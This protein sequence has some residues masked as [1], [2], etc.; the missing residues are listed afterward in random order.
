MQ[1]T[2]TGVLG[3]VLKT[4]AR[5][6]QW[7]DLVFSQFSSKT[8]AHKTYVTHV[9]C[10]DMK[11]YTGTSCKVCEN[12]YCLNVWTRTSRPTDLVGS[13]PGY[14]F[15]LHSSQYGPLDIFSHSTAANMAQWIFFTLLSS[16]R[17]AMDFLF[18]RT[19]QQPT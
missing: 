6:A 2:S 8:N 5:V 4:M 10:H 15:P 18:F 16:P 9:T 11:P 12:R 19:P 14:F 17:G 3:C 1:P 7:I 13:S